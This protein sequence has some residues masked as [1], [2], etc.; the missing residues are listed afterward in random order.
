MDVGCETGMGTPYQNPLFLASVRLVKITQGLTSS[1]FGEVWLALLHKRS[2]R[3]R[4][5]WRLQ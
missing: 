5:M 2:E 4:G 3:F 1:N